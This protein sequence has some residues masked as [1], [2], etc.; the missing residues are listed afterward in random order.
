MFSSDNDNSYSSI[1]LAHP[2]IVV[3]MHRSGTAL[4]VQLLEQCGVFMGKDQTRNGESA[5]FQNVNKETLDIIGCNWRCLEFLP[6]VD[7]MYSHYE[8]LYHIVNKKMKSNLI[9]DYFGDHGVNLADSKESMWG[10]KD[11]RNSLLLP[12]WHRIFADPLVLNIYRDG[13]DVALSLL[14]REIKW[15]KDKKFFDGDELARRYVSYLTLWSEYIRRI[16][17][18]LEKID[19]HYTLQYERLLDDPE[20]EIGKLIE[21]AGIRTHM[22]LKDLASGV[23]GTRSGRYLKEDFSWIADINIDTSLL[24]EL[25]YL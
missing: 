15:E 12:L 5:F 2:I 8:W 9:R 22:S 14:V 4:L 13:R 3:G 1:T 20:A 16:Q 19:R 23:D 18:S 17:K 10:W 11:P 7:K 25:G 21:A 24:G 6:E